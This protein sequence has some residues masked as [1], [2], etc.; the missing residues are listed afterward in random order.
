MAELEGQ[1]GHDI[2]LLVQTVAIFA[3][4]GTRRHINGT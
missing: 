3:P 2:S 4:R 1:E